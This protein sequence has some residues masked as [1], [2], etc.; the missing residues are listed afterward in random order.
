MS[1]I[2]V[3]F[4]RDIYSILVCSNFTGWEGRSK[5]VVNLMID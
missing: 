1:V 2:G 4:S 3:H 5:C